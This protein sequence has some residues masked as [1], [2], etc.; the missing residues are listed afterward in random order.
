MCLLSNISMQSLKIGSLNINGGRDRHKRALIFEVATQKKIDVLFLQETHTIQTDD[1]L[2]LRV[3][4]SCFLS[5]GTNLSAG[6]ALLFSQHVVLSHVVV[7]EVEQGR[8]QIIQATIRETLFVFINIYAY[9]SAVDRIDPF[10]KLNNTLKQLS[11]SSVVVVGGDWNCTTNF[12]VDRNA[13]EPHPPSASLLS[14][15][16]LESDLVDAWRKLHPTSRQYTWVKV[17]EGRVSAARLD[18][19]YVNKTCSNRSTAAI[20]SPVG[21]SDHHLVTVNF[22]LMVNPKDLLIGILTSD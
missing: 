9:T 13:G 7:S 12:S 3:G 11:S 6:V 10:H 14:N 17:T 15:V 22:S 21:F 2:G 4:G 19:F 20:I 16:I 18:R 1:R 8:I 5:H